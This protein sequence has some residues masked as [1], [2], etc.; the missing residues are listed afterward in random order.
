MKGSAFTHRPT[1]NP[2]TLLDDILKANSAKELVTRMQCI[3]Y[4]TSNASVPMEKSD[5]H[6]PFVDFFFT[7]C[8]LQNGNIK[9]INF[10]S[11]DRKM[12]WGYEK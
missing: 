6:S 11:V 1:D 4:Y 7:S 2:C 10:L 5:V 3:F 9:C 12:S 8:K